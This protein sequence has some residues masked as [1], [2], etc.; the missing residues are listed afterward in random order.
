MSSTLIP[1][2]TLAQHA[3]AWRPTSDSGRLDREYVIELLGRLKASGNA[4]VPRNLGDPER[5]GKNGLWHDSLNAIL[6]KEN[7]PFRIVSAGPTKRIASVDA[8]TGALT[9]AR[10]TAASRR[11]VLLNARVMG[12]TDD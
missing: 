8:A 3:L 11:E 12:L 6:R 2:D 9:R 5:W 7:V 1:W 4:G 10:A